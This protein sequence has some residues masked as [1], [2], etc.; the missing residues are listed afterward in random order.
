MKKLLAFLAA[1]CA[2][3]TGFQSLSAAEVTLSG[4]GTDPRNFATIQQALDAIGSGEGSFT[5]KIPKGTYEEVLYYNGAADITLSG[6][7][8]ARYGADVVIAKA[9]DGDLYLL[10]NYT[11]SSQKGRCL[12]EFEGTGNLTVENITFHNTF[13]RGSVKGS[14]TQAETIGFDSTGNLAAYNCAFKSH[15]DTLR[16]TGKSWFY[17]CYVEGDTDFIWME[18]S[19]KV[20]LF[21]ECEIVSV[22]D[23][24][25]NDPTS[26]IGAPRMDFGNT[27]A[28][29]LVI[30][31]SKISTQEGETTYLARTPWNSGYYNQVAFV[32][33]TIEGDIEDVLWKGEALTAEG[34]PETIIG[35]KI[36]A[37]TAKNIGAKVD[38]RK[39][40]LS[41]A[42][43]KKEFG[44][45]EAILNR[46]YDIATLKYKKDKDTYWDIKEFVKERGWKVSKDSSK[47]IV[48]ADDKAANTVY[49]FDAEENYSGLK[50]EGFFVAGGVLVGEAG[51]KISFPV[52][53]K[54]VVSV[55][56]CLA[57]EG[58]IRA[59]KQGE[60]FYNFD[61]GSS[62]KFKEKAYIVYVGS[63]NV[64]ITATKKTTIS[65]I[66][67]EPDK[68]VKFVPVQSIVVSSEDGVTEL[69]GKKS[70]QFSA[71]LNPVRPTNADYEWS[72]SDTSAATISPEGQLVA[73]A[74][75]E[76]KT[77][78]VKATS[79]D[80]KGVSAEFKLKILRPD[81]NSFAVTW[82][83]SLDAS[84]SLEGTSENS[85]LA[86]AKNAVP[87]AGTWKYNSSK[88]NSTFAKG[89]ITYTGYTGEISGKDTVYVDFPIT[90]VETIEITEIDA[91]FGNHGT[92][93]V[94][95]LIQ[96]IAGGS[97]T[98]LAVD[99]SRKARSAKMSYPTSYTIPK[100][101]TANIRVILY[102]RDGNG[103]TSI[104][105]GKAPTVATITISGKRK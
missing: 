59:D 86:V 93:N 100:G 7:T 39:D 24:N 68:A 33:N 77:I 32:N 78:T 80:E 79:K 45:R 92:S 71:A 5:I 22:Y 4:T 64:T 30:F 13:E 103:D 55:T 94:G 47:S 76:D 81:P 37:T 74:V 43:V 56:G 49:T 51:S 2:M 62:A 61:T 17:Q 52:K 36:D 66:V 16:M 98:E 84:N 105:G 44:G 19:G 75:P 48:S 40:I 89:G 57:G 65:R 25:H 97:K 31:N 35:W 72:V 6:D 73:A 58:T 91:A 23:E 10:K 69:L 63:A 14:N 88:I 1:G 11:T 18:S 21:E 26:Y 83:D 28:K 85:E 70:L 101:T 87:S 8:T 29:G 53:T 95:V 60:A 90:A 38:G 3:L 50:I 41:A 20:A 82:L 9:N 96:G 67:V 15:Q 12:F 34:I 54:S 46:H 104:A 42:D 27:A 102:G 99:E